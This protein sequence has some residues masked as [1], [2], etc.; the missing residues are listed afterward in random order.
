[1]ASFIRQ[2]NMC[3]C[4]SDRIYLRNYYSYI[5]LIACVSNDR[6]PN[7]QQTLL[8][9]FFSF[10]ADGFHKITSLDNGGLKFDRD[11]MEFS[12]PSFQRGHPF[13]LE[14]IKRKIAVAAAA[15]PA[16]GAIVK[17]ETLNRV[18]NEVKVMRGKQEVLDD[19]F[20]AMK[21][22]NEALWREVVMLRQKHMKQQQIV[23]KVSVSIISLRRGSLYLISPS[24]VDPIPSNNRPTIWTREHGHET[25]F[26]ADVERGPD[27][28]QVAEDRQQ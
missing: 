6:P 17:P 26:A 12:H 4:D 15:A 2:L 28:E 7:S 18:L 27:A 21:Q 25:T 9:L 11:D 10:A 20:S 23:N 5:C 3:K 24:A 16:P 8:N 1:M 22:E 13:M 14:N 19:R